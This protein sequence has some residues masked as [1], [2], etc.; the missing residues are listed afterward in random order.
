MLANIFSEI[1]HCVYVAKTLTYMYRE[2]PP[3]AHFP[4]VLSVFQA[5]KSM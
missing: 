2:P 5:G 4:L 1:L 3:T